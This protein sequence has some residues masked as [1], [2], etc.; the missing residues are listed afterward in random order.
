MHQYKNHWLHKLG[1]MS[2]NQFQQIRAALHPEGR[3]SCVGDKCHQLHATIDSLN[4]HA[5]RAFVLDC[6]CSFDE[7]GKA[8]NHGTIMCV[9]IILPNQI[10]I[11]LISLCL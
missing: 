10:N 8:S 3:V 9:D 11:K 4:K 2:E 7:G 6:E 1:I 5:K